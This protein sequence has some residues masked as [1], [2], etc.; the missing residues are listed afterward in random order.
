MVQQQPVLFSGT[1]AD[2][3]AY[4]YVESLQDGDRR[5]GQ[6]QSQMQEEQTAEEERRAKLAEKG[7]SNNS[8]KKTATTTTKKKKNEQKQDGKQQAGKTHGVPGEAV[9]PPFTREDVVAAAKVARAHD[10]ISKL[11]LGYDTVVGNGLLS[12]GQQQR[13]AIAR[14]VMRDAPI[15]LLDE[16]TSALDP[17]SARLVTDAIRRCSEGRTVIYVTHER[18]TPPGFERVA[19]PPPPPTRRQVLLSSWLSSSSGHSGAGGGGGGGGG[20]R[21]VTGG[22]AGA[23]GEGRGRGDQKR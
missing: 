10:F 22:G 12:G 2:N 9:P 7:N 21:A 13:I 6:R 5:V 15:L 16:V 20:K 14:A 3:I 1:V 18:E 17:R 8:D 11:P 23:A 19:L 4:G